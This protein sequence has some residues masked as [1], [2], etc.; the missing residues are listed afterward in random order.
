[1]NNFVGREVELAQLRQAFLAPNPQIAVVYGRRRVGK[2]A[3]I[4]KALEGTPF[5][6][7]EGLE[8]QSTQQQLD[9]FCLQLRRQTGI[10]IGERPKTWREALLLLEPWL[11]KNQGCIVLDELQWMANYRHAMVSD[12]KMVWD[13]VFS[14]MA[15]VNLVLSG[16]IASF[17]LDKVVHSRALYGRTDR[18]IHLRPFQLKDTRRMLPQ[19]GA[20]EC[21]E[22]QMM[23]G[24]VPKYLELIG[25]GPSLYLAVE[26][27][28]F[29]EN[30]FLCQEYERIFTSHFGRNEEFSKILGALAKHPYGLLRKELSRKAE[31]DTGG[32]LSRHLFD[33]ESAGFITG[34]RPM[35]RPVQSR[36]LSYRICDAFIR[37]HHALMSQTHRANP[38]LSSRTSFSQLV[39]RP[40]Y[41]TWR[42]HA[43]ENLCLQHSHEIA[44]RLGFHGVDYTCGPWFRSK[45][46]GECGYQVDMAYAR[47]DHVI[48]L[49]EIKSSRNP[50]GA[51]VIE[52]VQT[53]VALMQEAFPRHRI[54]PV[55]IHDGPLTKEVHYTP[56]FE[57][58]IDA[59]SLL[60]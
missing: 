18:V 39:H 34:L 42:G 24:G 31:V 33:L 46:S 57:S 23:F 22:A 55:L 6:N 44:A 53:K 5:L 12:L 41:H 35:D 8:D 32:G 30:G 20:T 47:A 26:D 19:F 17:M 38:Q 28:A 15:G 3:L 21:L 2:S 16:S 4:A 10:S 56:Y 25:N 7:F 37:F 11:R 50:I 60:E 54:Q 43:L 59:L 13:Q 52:E 49:C 14:R 48:T 36:I 1:M 27:L 51:K 29:S 58:R 45:A 40:A 9:N